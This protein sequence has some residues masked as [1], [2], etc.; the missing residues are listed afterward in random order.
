M[1]ARAGIFICAMPGAA[2]S[3]FSP[4]SCR[5]FV[6]FRRFLA[7][8]APDLLLVCRRICRRSALRH[9]ELW[10]RAGLIRGSPRVSLCFVAGDVSPAP[11]LTTC[12]RAGADRLSLSRRRD[13]IVAAR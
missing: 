7:S 9:P 13:A 1:P 4:I 8:P 5:P 10:T 6:D 12:F 2:H 11:V 3:G